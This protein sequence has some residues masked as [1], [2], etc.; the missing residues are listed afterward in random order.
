MIVTQPK[1]LIGAFVN[2]Q[3]GLPHDNP[4]GHFTALGLV[5]SDRLVAGI[6]Y[7]NAA[8]DNICI[9]AGAVANSLWATP[10]ALYAMFDYPFNQLGMR[11]VTAPIRGK[12][13]KTQRLV[14]R[15]GFVYEGSLRQF[16]PDDD[17]HL[18]GLLREECQYLNMR[19]AA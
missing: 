18:Y 2:M 6:I 16:Y 9:H 8:T 17:L 10:D 13:L 1:E 3:Q 11:R 14:K 15:M 19:K 5:R 4:W 12:N 7:N